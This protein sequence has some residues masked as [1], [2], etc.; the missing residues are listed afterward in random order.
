LFRLILF[1]VLDIEQFTIFEKYA[2]FP[3]FN[4][5]LLVNG[6]ETNNSVNTEMLTGEI[7]SEIFFKKY[8][9]P[10]NFLPQRHSKKTAFIFIFILFYLFIYFKF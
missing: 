10:K 2:A 5:V 4:V 9:E 7:H 6:I 1:S 8:V 3:L